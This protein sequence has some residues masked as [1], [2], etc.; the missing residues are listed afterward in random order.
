MSSEGLT[1][2]GLMKIQDKLYRYT[3]TENGTI[4][5]V[6][7][8]K[9]EPKPQLPA[10]TDPLTQAEVS[11]ITMEVLAVVR[12]VALDPMIYLCFSFGARAARTQ[13]NGPFVQAQ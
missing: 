5:L 6:P 12:K 9:P 10:A 4:N 3:Q 8:P 7:I 2:L 1:S 13:K 11:N